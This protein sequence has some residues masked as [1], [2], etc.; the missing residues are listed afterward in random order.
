VPTVTDPSADNIDLDA[1]EITGRCVV[2]VTG[3]DV[4]AI[5]GELRGDDG[6]L[7]GWTLAKRSLFG[8]GLDVVLPAS[9]V[10]GIGPDAV[11]IR[12]EDRLVPQ[13]ELVELAGED[14]PEV[15]DEAPTPVA[16]TAT[17]TFNDARYRDVLCSDGHQI[18]RVDRF[19][20]DPDARTIGSLRLDGVTGLERYVSWRVLEA[21]GDDAV[22]VE[23]ERVL[24]LEDGPREKGSRRAYTALGK[25]VLDDNGR[26]LGTVEDVEFD[27]TDGR[28]T[29]LNLGDDTIDGSRLRGIGPHAVVV[30]RA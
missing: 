11:V 5:D 29:A 10:I 30:R 23:D 14:A 28:I 9:R 3:H 1:H 12:D 24:R 13:E 4:A 2:A 20:I 17:A 21:F 25:C 27:P 19:V 6:E 18:G 8:G 15:D 26:E 16:P 7:L 22:T